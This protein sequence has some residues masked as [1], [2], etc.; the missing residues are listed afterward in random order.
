M[1]FLKKI[2]G[3]GTDKKPAENFW[4]W[5]VK[6][7]QRFKKIIDKPDKAGVFLD[8][9]IAQMKHFNPWFKALAGPYDDTKYELII[10]ADGDIALFCKVEELVKAAPAVENWVITAHKQPIGMDKMR[11]DMLGHEFSA[12]NMKFYPVNDPA[13]PDEIHIVL[14]HPDYNEEQKNDFQSGGMIYLENALGEVNT[15]TLIDDY[16]VKGPPGDG[17]ELI[18]LLKLEEYL[19]WREKEFIEKYEKLEA[20]R[21]GDGYSVL[22]SEDTAGNPVFAT[23]NT[24]YKNWDFKAAYPWLVQVDIDFKGSDRGLPDKKQMG[25]LQ[26]I[27]DQL[28]KHLSADVINV[29]HD[30]HNNRRS[31]YAYAADYKEVSHKIHEYFDTLE[32]EFEVVFFIRKDKYWKNMEWFFNAGN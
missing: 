29:G 17:T 1:G 18:P 19:R 7:E 31:V 25:E 3:K 21:P 30:T 2:M 16:E 20:V 12:D 26:A 9:L 5:F 11:I 8:E 13:Y 10:T 22:E 32:T 15:A 14:V 27:E 28:F 23:V 6:N 4:N 24:G